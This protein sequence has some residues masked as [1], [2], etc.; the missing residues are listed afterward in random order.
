MPKKVPKIVREI[1]NNP[2][3]EINFAFQKNISYSQYSMYKQCPH[4][5]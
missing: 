1:Q 4:K 5:W 3:E 2:P